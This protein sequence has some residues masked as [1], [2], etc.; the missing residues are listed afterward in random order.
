MI[1]S[2]GSGV[3]QQGLFNFDNFLNGNNIALISFGDNISSNASGDAEP[4]N[5]VEGNTTTEPTDYYYT[6]TKSTEYHVCF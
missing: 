6:T 1:G 4:T 5:T 2:S 3:T